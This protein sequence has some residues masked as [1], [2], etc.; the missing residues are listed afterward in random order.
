MLYQARVVAK[1]GDTVR[2]RANASSSASVLKSIRLG[3][4]VDVVAEL[5]GWHKIVYNNQTGYMMNQFLEKVQTS[6]PAP[7]N[8][9]WYVRVECGSEADAKAIAAALK[10]CGNAIATQG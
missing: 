10:L 5:D 7:D 1:S 9:I 8:K 3:E 6:A 4:I 2:M